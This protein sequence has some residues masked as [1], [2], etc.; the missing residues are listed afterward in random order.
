MA[1]RSWTI[2]LPRSFDDGFSLRIRHSQAY[3][4]HYPAVTNHG[5]EQPPPTFLQ[6]QRTA[7]NPT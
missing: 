1:T 7:P 5:R 4:S 3:C 2:M 6:R